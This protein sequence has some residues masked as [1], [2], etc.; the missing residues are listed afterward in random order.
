M[1]DEEQC[2]PDRLEVVMCSIV[3]SDAEGLLW[4]EGGRTLVLDDPADFGDLITIATGRLDLRSDRTVNLAGMPAIA[5]PEALPVDE[6]EDTVSG[7]LNVD[8]WPLRSKGPRPT[9]LECCRTEAM[10]HGDRL[11]RSQ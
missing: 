2:E 7:D 1:Y 5:A 11:S 6:E 4:K 9:N 10:C 8:S 3:A